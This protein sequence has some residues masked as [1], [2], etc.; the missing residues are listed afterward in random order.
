[1]GAKGNQ[2]Y[3]NRKLS[4]TNTYTK[5]LV[6]DNI[7]KLVHLHEKQRRAAYTKKTIHRNG[8]LVQLFKK[9][10]PVALIEYE[11]FLFVLANDLLVPLDVVHNDEEFIEFHRRFNNALKGVH[12][13]IN[14]YRDPRY[15]G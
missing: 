13:C 1:M 4:I 14:L 10:Q 2:S 15:R 7:T 3:K 12:F 6:M 9:Q 11:E 5:E 8:N